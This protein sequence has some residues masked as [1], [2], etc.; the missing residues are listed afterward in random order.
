MLSLGGSE[1]EFPALAVSAQSAP[2]CDSAPWSRLGIRGGRPGYGL[3]PRAL[4][5]TGLCP[6]RAGANLRGV[7]AFVC[8]GAGFLLAVVWFDLMHDVQVLRLAAGDDP[9]DA[10]LSIARYYRRV[11]TDARPMNRLVA[12]AMV[13]TLAAIAVELARDAVPAWMGWT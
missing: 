2:L 11:T 4:A 9:S 8:A 1:S 6:E 13:A 5:L 12:L 10:L 3:R 7:R